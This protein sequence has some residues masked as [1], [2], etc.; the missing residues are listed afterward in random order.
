MVLSEQTGVDQ[1]LGN[2]PSHEHDG[3]E[4]GLSLG[5]K[6]TPGSQAPG[7]SQVPSVTALWVLNRGAARPATQIDSVSAFPFCADAS[8]V[9]RGVPRNCVCEL[10]G[11]ER[12]A[13]TPC[14]SCRLTAPAEPRPAGWLL[15]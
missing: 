9:A 3:T 15:Q 2:F 14:H 10:M 8:L 5:Q 4:L 12:A 11:V 6:W 13:L 1:Y 7:S